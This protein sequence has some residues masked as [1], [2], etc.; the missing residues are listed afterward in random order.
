MADPTGSA[1]AVDAILRHLEGDEEAL[2]E[3]A[4]QFAGDTFFGKLGPKGSGAERRLGATPKPKA[5][6]P[7]SKLRSGASKPLVIRN[8]HLAG[9]KH[10]VTGIPFDKDGFPD[11]SKVSKKN[12][13]IRMS[14]NRLDDEREA[15]RKAGLEDTPEGYTWHHHQDKT[16]MQLVPSKIHADTGHTGGHAILHHEQ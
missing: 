4:K 12:V 15:N 7:A 9:K 6:K 3:L 11:F 16:T 14:G 1:D 13:K 5:K 2:V 8:K 10:P